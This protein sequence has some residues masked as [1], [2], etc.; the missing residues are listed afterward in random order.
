MRHP[1]GFVGP[2]FD[3]RGM[4]VW[5]FTGGLLSTLIRLA[6]WERP[7]DE[8]RVVPLDEPLLPPFA[9]DHGPGR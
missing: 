4:R 9:D 6:G 7:W 3:V 1:S 5:G 2:A 8:A